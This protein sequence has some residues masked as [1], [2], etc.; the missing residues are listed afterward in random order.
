M[1][2]QVDLPVVI[3]LLI[4]YEASKIPSSAS[5]GYATRGFGARQPLRDALSISGKGSNTTP[6]VW[7]AKMSSV[8]EKVDAVS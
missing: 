7:G 5:I 6:G 2:D 8:S 1:V 3:R 4:D